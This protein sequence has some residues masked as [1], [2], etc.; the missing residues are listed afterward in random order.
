MKAISSRAVEQKQTPM[1]STTGRL[2]AAI[3]VGTTKVCTLIARVDPHGGI[4]VL[5]VGVARTQGMHKALVVDMEAVSEAVRKSWSKATA[6]LGVDAPVYGAY[7][8][9]TGS[10]IVSRR[11]TGAIH[12]LDG[13][14]EDVVTRRD[15]QCAMDLSRPS[16]EEH[17]ALLHVLPISYRVDSA[18]SVR[19][20]LGLKGRELTADSHSVI[21][22]VASMEN[23]VLAV[24]GAGIAVQ[25]MVL[26]PLASAEAVLT[27][28]EREMG[29]V[30]VDIGGGTSDIAIFQ[31][32]VMTY[33][34][35]LPVAGYQFT[36][37]LSMALGLPYDIAEAAKVKF[38]HLIADEVEED[39][40]VEFPEK[41][42]EPAHQVRRRDM[43][44]FLNDR[45]VEL[46]RLIR[47]RVKQAGLEVMP[48]GGIVFTG[49]GA[50]LPGWEQLTHEYFPG[51]VR[52]AQPRDILGLPASLKSA[53][54]STSVGI[55]LWSIHHP[56]E[57]QVYK[58]HANSNANYA[59]GKH[60]LHLLAQVLGTR[61]AYT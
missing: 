3:D 14:A 16:V 25:G 5:G 32:G 15:M 26:E 44:R 28:D 29:V 7:V 37:D 19:N 60:W 61:R 9:V 36:N 4:E 8:G 1:S 23:V 43:C 30:L 53:S 55:L 58:S 57:Q 46:L 24:E 47:L 18:D 45:A 10:H 17:Q 12:R 35:A 38:G 33:T 59:K 49:G 2:Y 40:G 52:I 31:H 56:V 11:T 22:E 50:N 54:Y 27:G 13:L 20:P 48:P 41:H 21:G 6:H 34:S 39:E 42:G 51:L